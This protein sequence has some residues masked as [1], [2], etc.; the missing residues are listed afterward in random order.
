MADVRRRVEELRSLIRRHDALYFVEARPEI[1]DRDYDRLIEELRELEAAHPGLVTPDSPTQRVGGTPLPGFKSVPH[2][3]AMLS[4]DNTY[5]EEELRAF[6]E[7]VRKGLGSGDA[8]VTYTVEPKID[9]VA[10]NLVYENGVFVLGTTRGDG[11]SGDDITQNI[12]TIRG[13]PL[14]LDSAPEGRAEIRG[15]VF[16]T[17]EGFSEMNARFEEAGEKTFANPRNAAAGTLKSLDPAVPASRPLRILTYHIVEAR[18]RHALSRHSE[19]IATLRAW[20]LP[21]NDCETAAGIDSVLAKAEVW[22]DRRHELPF[23]VDGLVIK[24]DDLRLQEDLGSTSKAPRWAIAFKYPAEEAITQVEKIAVQV[25]RTGVVTPVAHL[26]PVFVS[27]S[28][29]SRATLHNADEVERLDVREGDWV[30]VEKGGEVIPKV[31][32]V[33]VERREGRP[34]KFRMP[35]RCPSCDSVLVRAEG[36]VAWRCIRIDCPVQVERR[37]EHFA[38]RGSMRIEGLGEKVIRSLIEAGLVRNVADL[39][40]LTVDQ[41][42][43]LERMGKKSAENLVASIEASKTRDLSRLIF[44]L[45]IRQVGSRAAT[46]LAEHFGSMDVLMAAGEEELVDVEEI[47]PIVAGEILRFLADSDNRK[48]IERLRGHGLMMSARPAAGGGEGP[49]AGKVVVATGKLDHFTRTEIQETIARF[50]GRSGDSVSKK[51]DYLVAGRDAGSKLRK[52]V[53]LGIPV[54]SEREF[55]DLCGLP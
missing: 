15:E 21:V 19:A 13:L 11:V 52:A 41:I 4:L 20:G 30:A 2:S 28:T 29:V 3:T 34:R 35:E 46:L 49:L 55:M 5:N 6:D 8:P 36:E 43:P 25:G 7:R 45:G 1:S 31:T 14:R 47:G 48:I 42:V 12:R 9:G 38:A 40:E 37:I 22:R 44:A 26:A 16:L 10:V 24:L 50:G 18:R 39:Y 53:Q 17:R 32:R 54:L 51:T 23:E 33:L 27:G